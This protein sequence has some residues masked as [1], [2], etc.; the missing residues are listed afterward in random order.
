MTH[1]SGLGRLMADTPRRGLAPTSVPVH[2]PLVLITEEPNPS[3]RQA[4]AAETRAQAKYR[5]RYVD[6][7]WSYC[8][9]CND[10]IAPEHYRYVVTGPHSVIVI[11]LDCWD[12]RPDDFL[13]GYEELRRG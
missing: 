2:V 8:E 13:D 9:I 4:D 5:A 10:D 11:C 6:G 7:S 1:N 3:T 12:D